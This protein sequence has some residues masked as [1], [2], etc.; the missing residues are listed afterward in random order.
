LACV[1]YFEPVREQLLFVYA[2]TWDISTTT[3][4]VFC[5]DIYSAGD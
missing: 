3:F 5:D 2:I 1:A 4:F